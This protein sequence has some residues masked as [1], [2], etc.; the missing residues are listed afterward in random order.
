[1]Q[2][3]AFLASMDKV[4]QINVTGGYVEQAARARDAIESMLRG[5]A[6]ALIQPMA[7][8]PA[9]A[10]A[11]VPSAEPAIVPAEDVLY[12]E[13]VLKFT[14]GDGETVTGDNIAQAL[15][16][17]TQQMGEEIAGTDIK[18]LADG[19]RIMIN[20]KMFEVCK[21]GSEAWAVG[22]TF[23]EASVGE[24]DTK[25]MGADGRWEDVTMSVCGADINGNFLGVIEGD[26]AD[27]RV[28][29]PE[30]APAAPAGPALPTG[31]GRPA[32]ANSHN[33]T[34][35]VGEDGS[36]NVR[37]GDGGHV[38]AVG[39]Q[40]IPR[41]AN[42]A[43]I[44]L[45]TGCEMGRYGIIEDV[46][47]DFD[48]S[49]APVVPEGTRVISD[50]EF[51]YT[52][53][54]LS[55]GG[56]TV[57]VI[58]T[59]T[60]TQFMGLS[61]V[62]RDI[63][64]VGKVEYMLLLDREKGELSILPGLTLEVQVGKETRTLEIADDGLS[65]Q[66]P[67][68]EEPLRVIEKDNVT[69]EVWGFDAITGQAI[70][71]TTITEEH[72]GEQVEAVFETF[73]KR[74]NVGG[75]SLAVVV[76]ETSIDVAGLTGEARDTA[77]A[78]FGEKGI[79]RSTVYMV[80]GAA[81]FR[82]MRAGT[83][84]CLFD[85]VSR[86]FFTSAGKH[87]VTHDGFD[88][89]TH[90]KPVVINGVSFT[91]EM[92]KALVSYG[93]DLTAAERLMADTL[94]SGVGAVDSTIL[95]DSSGQ[96]AWSMS[97]VDLSALDDPQT[98]LVGMG[99]MNAG[100]FFTRELDI[101][102]ADLF[103]GVRAN[104]DSCG[105]RGANGDRIS[106]LQIA[107]WFAK[108]SD[109]GRANALEGRVI[110]GNIINLERGLDRCGVTD[111]LGAPVSDFAMFASLASLS[112]AERQAT[113]AGAIAMTYDPKAFSDY[114]GKISELN[115]HYLIDNQ[116]DA[117]GM[118]V[119]MFLAGKNSAGRA[120]AV[121]GV[122]RLT[123]SDVV[124]FMKGVDNV[125]AGLAAGGH[126]TFD[127]SMAQA[128][129][130]LSAYSEDNLAETLLNID[131]GKVTADS[132]NAVI[133]GARQ[134]GVKM[135][136]FQAFLALAGMGDAA[137]TRTLANIKAG[138]VDSFAVSSVISAAKRAGVDAEGSQVFLALAGMDDKTRGETLAS[139]LEGKVL[140]LHI[141][142]IM[143][144]ADNA[145]IEV[146]AFQLFLALAGMDDATRG[147]TISNI[148]SGK[149]G[150]DQVDAAFDRIEAINADPEM[151]AHEDKKIEAEA[152]Q[153]LL[154]LAGMDDARRADFLEGAKTVT[155][156]NIIAAKFTAD[157][158]DAD[159]AEGN[160]IEATGFQ[161]F[162]ALAAMDETSRGNFLARI[163]SLT[164]DDMNKFLA[165][166]DSLD[167][168]LSVEQR[169]GATGFQAFMALGSMS[170]AKR[171]E[172]L[173]RM[174]SLTARDIINTTLFIDG[175][176]MKLGKGQKV[177]AGA[178][179][180]FMFLAGLTARERGNMYEFY[181]GE[182]LNA[183]NI[184]EVL[185]RA[186]ALSKDLRKG[187]QI[188]VTSFQVF[189]AL[190]T[191]TG[192]KRGEFLQEIGNIRASNI[193]STLNR[194]G[195]INSDLAKGEK[196]DATG[197]Q[198]FM[199]LASMDSDDRGEFLAGIEGTTAG[200][201]QK[202]LGEASRINSDL[203]I[204]N[205]MEI[206]SFQLFM[207]FASMSAEKRDDF[208]EGA[209]EVTAG[210]INA[211]IGR[212]S[213][214]NADP[215][216]TEKIEA[217][218]FQIFMALAG[219]DSKQRSDFLTG[220]QMTTSEHMNGM[221]SAIDSTNIGLEE[222]NKIEATGFQM[223]M[224]LA[225]MSADKRASFLEQAQTVTAS[226]MERRM[227]QIE[228]A[229]AGLETEALGKVEMSAFQV[230]MALASMTGEKRAE[231]LQQ[232]V[233]GEQIEKAN[234]AITSINSDSSYKGPRIEADA[235]QLF[236]ALISMN[237]DERAEFL[238]GAAKIAAGDMQTTNQA[239]NRINA[240][241]AA[242]EKIVASGLQ[243]FM[244]LASMSD[245]KRADFL[246]NAESVTA[247]DVQKFNGLVA[248]ANEGLTAERKM[249]VGS[250]QAFMA[251][252]G[253]DAKERAVFLAK[254]EANRVTGADIN[255]VFSAV[256]AVDKYTGEKT[257]ATS[258]QIFMSIAGS[259][260]KNEIMSRVASINKNA[261]TAAGFKEGLNNLIKRLLIF[262]DK[263]GEFGVQKMSTLG[264]IM[265]MTA[266]DAGF[267]SFGNVRADAFGEIN[268]RLANMSALDLAGLHRANN[269][270]RARSG[271]SEMGIISL[272]LNLIP[273]DKL[274]DKDGSFDTLSVMGLEKVLNG[275]TLV[276]TEDTMTLV[277]KD[278]AKASFSAEKTDVTADSMSA[279]EELGFDRPA[280]LTA[281]R[282]VGIDLFTTRFYRLD[283]TGSKISNIPTYI[284][285]AEDAAGVE[286]KSTGGQ[287]MRVFAVNPATGELTG[288]PMIL[289]QSEADGPVRLCTTREIE[290]ELKGT[291]T[292]GSSQD[293]LKEL[294]MYLPGYGGTVVAEEL[295][296]L[297]EEG[298]Q[299]DTEKGTGVI[300]SFGFKQ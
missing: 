132:V 300:E 137:R 25:Q 183:G 127:V 138:K 228:V 57:P 98:L 55:P 75:Y 186:A 282:S 238:D 27:L 285:R 74:I 284:A 208:L 185:G 270:M 160:K 223:F 38:L 233:F 295:Q 241:L 286:L 213:T 145:G 288:D 56:R 258:F 251:L 277:G 264:A 60:E 150:K 77:E 119:F 170:F 253:M 197:F 81:R 221:R 214:I 168:K 189:A 100:M 65:F 157:L 149:V 32:Y 246:L 299:V 29:G 26:G 136:G 53:R 21:G 111:E 199:A 36:I 103:D 161:I 18:R 158:L 139:A 230:F 83:E 5:V 255:K 252:A 17:A 165:K 46:T 244:A 23:Q 222:G 206:S 184:S 95:L 76:R 33:L 169:T 210:D 116:I 198:V 159:L 130:A 110:K 34:E 122:M 200:H 106:D 87:L 41:A 218:S 263:P 294:A 289:F 31:I 278:G 298:A 283:E 59:D 275:A 205:E 195:V 3:D 190:A 219:M 247:R 73:S 40:L 215:K 280:V 51:S 107:S 8:V 180:L 217:S 240:N 118:Q 124:T 115:G 7:A 123:V 174:E 128:V 209:A 126:E 287:I 265:L 237:R 272:L 94:L 14:L 188:E 71:T 144:R 112:G 39:M 193:E 276:A 86:A 207:A 235:T 229:N 269:G 164:S 58:D 171:Q 79:T 173:T 121:E 254:A 44:T 236:M 267:D 201:I 61:A 104:I 202:G 291:I 224:A 134:A 152:F 30:G 48:S 15:R 177:E 89:T 1:A 88:T 296:G 194:I 163:G 129:F 225:S 105:I 279:L 220:A 175:L 120:A 68:G 231:S 102:S 146:G 11:A 131:L 19:F 245:E 142:A 262:E 13:G 85:M 297:I 243:I 6:P 216:T 43:D 203:A 181:E 153:V 133:S 113:I 96:A 125:N 167:A 49:G 12:L 4:Y 9:E 69:T 42:S 35:Y 249:D 24:I 143:R 162:M 52:F 91:A 293:D 117:T 108:L 148:I 242:G 2:K 72:A 62:E 211:T 66:V 28:S 37:I 45:T 248:G 82:E 260:N 97:G 70:A 114:S 47:V 20:G 281:L 99:K 290:G 239:I 154:A 22:D 172:F 266:V 63:P 10:K 147:N 90:D 257:E 204:E 176:N 271:M 273:N 166:A 50:N 234:A 192:E 259:R 178:F 135:E 140:D 93:A 80:D 101:F 187:Q 54:E 227:Y 226:Q 232:S 156:G 141:T 250:F 109:K 191:M 292:A 84:T 155:A 274:F 261:G 256:E 16:A 151:A 179:Q 78:S 196:I 212:I 67:Q 64:G 268:S 92:N 182:P